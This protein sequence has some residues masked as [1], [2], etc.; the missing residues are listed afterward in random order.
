MKSHEIDYKVH[1]KDM[2]FVELELDKNETVIGEAGAMMYMHDGIDYE[3][4]MGDG[5][6]AESGIFRL[7]TNL[8]VPIIG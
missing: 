6:K 5:S 4:K 1:G 8:G 3:V 2:Q 7:F